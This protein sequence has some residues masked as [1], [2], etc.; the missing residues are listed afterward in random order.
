MYA[1]SRILAIL[2][3]V[4][5]AVA[6][7][8]PGGPVIFHGTEVAPLG[9]AT[10]VVEPVSKKLFVGNLSFSGADGFELLT[11]RA[12]GVK[13][14]FPWLP[15]PDGRELFF[16]VQT[17]LPGIDPCIRLVTGPSS[18]VD[19]FVDFSSTG[20]DGHLIEICNDGTPVAQTFVPLGDH[21]SCAGEPSAIDVDMHAVPA[22][23]VS[24]LVT[25][26]EPA[27][28]I[29]LTTA[30][31][32]TFSGPAGQ[33]A[34]GNELRAYPSNP[35]SQPELQ[36][37]VV[38]CSVPPP[39]APYTMEFEDAAQLIEGRLH[40]GTMF[41]IISKDLDAEIKFNLTVPAGLQGGVEMEAKG[42]ETSQGITQNLKFASAGDTDVFYAVGQLTDGSSGTADFSGTCDGLSWTLIPDFSEFGS[43]GA[44][45]Q[46]F[47]GVG[48]PL[49][50][51]SPLVGGIVV[52]ANAFPIQTGVDIRDQF[53]IA[54]DYADPVP[55]TISTGTFVANRIM[56]FGQGDVPALL[57]QTG[58]LFSSASDF[59]IPF[60]GAPNTVRTGDDGFYLMSGFGGGFAKNWVPLSY[61]EAV[62]DGNTPGGEFT[63][64]PVVQEDQ[65]GIEWVPGPSPSSQPGETDWDFVSRL[66]GEAS[67]LARM[68]I[69]MVPDGVGVAL[70]ASSR[71]TPK[72]DFGSVIKTGHT[73]TAE[74]VHSDETVPFAILPA[75]PAA[76]G[77]Q[78]LHNT[79]E[80][81]SMWIN[82]GQVMDIVIPGDPPTRGTTAATQ[83]VSADFIHVIFLDTPIAS[84]VAE[85]KLVMR[86]Y[87]K[88]H[89]LFRGN[90]TRATSVGPAPKRTGLSM[91]APYPN[92]FNPTTTLAFNIATAGDVSIRVYN[93]RGEHVATLHSGWMG[94]GAHSVNWDGV[95]HR[96][97][98]AAS[99]V[100]LVELRAP[101]GTRHA[102]MNLLK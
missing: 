27:P 11:G 10:L 92:P 102:K 86:G 95:N 52:G 46:L 23:G 44:N 60:T 75:W 82:L 59:T 43:P 8:Q 87:E 51:P 54:Y 64:E 90:K 13:V 65:F 84:P 81:W 47:D 12:Q 41:G 61:V 19:I 73:T 69:E 3:V 62:D 100:Y 56:V 96:G 55:V 88:A 33:I 80:T 83:V 79:D 53:S 22:I 7:S 6:F 18:G 57:T 42:S 101:D 26:F 94:A 74:F 72:T 99:G 15:A 91:R 58:R 34:T 89:R 38:L 25:A 20:A 24:P 77:Y 1:R 78:V 40:R 48:L 30:A 45:V 32:T 63:F 21:L 17:D 97:E 4:L 85:S 14:K 2:A 93:V 68:G 28:M 39:S 5:P 67:P 98:R 16:E 37:V 36:K 71:Q 29:M 70:Y 9:L 31:P 35:T 76:I 50:P 66:S 49:G